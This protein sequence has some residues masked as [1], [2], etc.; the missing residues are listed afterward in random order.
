MLERIDCVN[1]LLPVK[2]EQFFEEGDSA[3]PVSRTICY[4][5]LPNNREL[6]T[7]KHSLAKTMT[8]IARSRSRFDDFCSGELPPA[9]HILICGRA[10]K[11][12]DNIQLMAVALASQYGFAP[13][14]LPKHTATRL[15][16][17]IIVR[18]FQGG[19]LT[20]HPTCQWQWC[21]SSDAAKAQEVGTSA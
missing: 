21:I 8:Q 12:K 1:A 18:T 6:H 3:R 4:S 5:C 11:V 20:Q 19:E 14:H 17:T 13:K 10:A 15:I 16:S 7:R 2:S 9:R